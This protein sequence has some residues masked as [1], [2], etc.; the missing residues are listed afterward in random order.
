MR[1]IRVHRRRGPI[2]ARAELEV[3][4]AGR[5][6]FVVVG[7]S[8]FSVHRPDGL[9][10]GGPT[11]HGLRQSD[12]LHPQH[13]KVGGCN[14]HA[15]ALCK[16]HDPRQVRARPGQHKVHVLAKRTVQ[17]ATMLCHRGANR[18][19]VQDQVARHRHRVLAIKR[20]EADGAG[21]HRAIQPLEVKRRQ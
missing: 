1:Q 8:N 7:G 19:E 3:V 9:G 2:V 4:G 18:Q 11:P 15:R 20:T 17:S 12:P 16:V 14:R 6:P 5:N 10:G 21:S 13:H